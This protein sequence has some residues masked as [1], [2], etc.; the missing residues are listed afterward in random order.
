MPAHEFPNDNLLLW[1]TPAPPAVALPT[2][3]GAPPAPPRGAVPPPPPSS[4]V[5]FSCVEFSPPQMEAFERAPAREP[6]DTAGVEAAAYDAEDDVEVEIIEAFD[7]ADFAHATFESILPAP[8]EAAPPSAVRPS[9]LEAR[10][11]A[12]L[13]AVPPPEDVPEATAPEPIVE[14]PVPS[15]STVVA[16]ALE[17]APPSPDV[18]SLGEAVEHVVEGAP[19]VMDDWARYVQVV[20]SVA[21]DAHA[22]ED[23]IELLPALLGE[24]RLDTPSRDAALLE[25]L[26][27]RGLLARTSSGFARADAVVAAAQAWKTMIMGGEA[28]LA[29]CGSGM[30]DE[31]TAALVAKLVGGAA[32][33]DAIRRELRGRGVCAFGLVVEAA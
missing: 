23:A 22:S 32:R 12:A 2:I 11:D 30:L 8:L 29:A 16:Q 20:Q 26:C 33:V 13:D 9:D 7:D 21:R 27:E 1:L 25:A 28:D 6:R 18:P 4:A 5:P 3:A 10:V 31:W 24:E 17:G 14:S 15:L 19:P